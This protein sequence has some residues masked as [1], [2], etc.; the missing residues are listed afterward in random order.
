VE[1]SLL[2]QIEPVLNPIWAWILH[3]EVP[4][5]WSVTACALILVA[6]VV[7]S[8]ADAREG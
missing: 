1:G 5:P 4:G 2:L 8:W 3:A 6:T 7:K